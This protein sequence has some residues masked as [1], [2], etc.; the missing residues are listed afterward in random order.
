MPSCKIALKVACPLPQAYPHQLVTWGDHVRK[1]RL[2]LG[3]LQKDVARILQVNKDTI[4][5]WENNRTSPALIHLP[6]IIDFLSYAPYFGSC[7]GL[8]EKIAQYRQFLGLSQRK[9]S[10]HIGV[11][12]STVE[13]WENCISTPDEEKLAKLNSVFLLLSKRGLYV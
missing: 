8:G 12:P 2:D 3:L 13:R 1:R 6:K 4:C 7:Q 9:L 5:N 11:D 10:K